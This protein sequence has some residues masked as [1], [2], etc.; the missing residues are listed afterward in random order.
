MG[1]A[2]IYASS[3]MSL[4]SFGSWAI[5]AGVNRLNAVMMQ[6]LPRNF[7]MDHL[8]LSLLATAVIAWI[9]P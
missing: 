1:K 4:A 2:Y 8:T 7:R 9:I 3:A 5:M 6:V